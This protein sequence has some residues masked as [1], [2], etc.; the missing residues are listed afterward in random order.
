VYLSFQFSNE[1]AFLTQ[2]RGMRAPSAPRRTRICAQTNLSVRLYSEVGL[3]IH[4]EGF[5]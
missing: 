2:Y 3:H 4:V 5:S 1:V